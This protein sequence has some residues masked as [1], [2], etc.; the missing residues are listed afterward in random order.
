MCPLK[1]PRNHGVCVSNDFI[2]MTN[3]EHPV[4]G[5]EC[6]E[7]MLR[8]YEHSHLFMNGEENSCDCGKY[9]SMKEAQEKTYGQ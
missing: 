1:C 7:C 9:A 4:H 2:P 6:K 3:K 5:M 8:C